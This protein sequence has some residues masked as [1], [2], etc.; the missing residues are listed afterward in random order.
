MENLLISA[1]LLG[2]NCKYSGGN[3]AMSTELVEKLG[4]RFRLW[5]ICPETAGGLPCPRDPSERLGSKVL[6][7]TGED[8]SRQFMKGACLAVELAERKGCRWALLKERSPSCG[9]GYIYDGSFSGRLVEGDG[10][11]A[12]LLKEKGLIAFGE[13][14][15]ELLLK[16]TEG[17]DEE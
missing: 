6:S 16:V 17:L 8:V 15:A 2:V 11:T 12:Q 3:N 1:C 13:S 7:C 10:L 14:E 9:S 4:Q 5:P